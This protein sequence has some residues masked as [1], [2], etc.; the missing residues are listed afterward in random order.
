MNAPSE[1]LAIKIMFGLTLGSLKDLK[2]W[3]GVLAE[4]FACFL[5]MFVI[6]FLQVNHEN[7][8]YI[9]STFQTGM[10]VG[11]LVM[12]LVDVFGPISG[13]FVNPVATFSFFLDGRMPFFQAIFY[14]SAQLSGTVAGCLLLGALIP[15]DMEFMPVIPQGGISA[16]RSFVIEVVLS[17][18]LFFT[19]L[20]VTDHKIRKVDDAVLYWAADYTGG[21]LAVIM[22]KILRF[23]LLYNKNQ[24]NEAGDQSSSS[25]DTDETDIKDGTLDL[26]F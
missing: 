8:S 9:P 3:V 25:Q 15:Y 6:V 5:M 18:V 13:G 23:G 16:L 26:K 17:I 24:S 12:V 20:S 11:V 14:I 2:M 10:A 1:Q 7:S 22:Y 19:C 21:V 4:F